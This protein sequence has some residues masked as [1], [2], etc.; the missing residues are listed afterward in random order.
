LDNGVRILFEKIPICTFGQR[1]NLGGTG[2]RNE[3]AYE[4]G[5]A[6]FIEHMVFKAPARAHPPKVAE[7]MDAIGGQANAFTSKGTDMLLRKGPGYAS[8]HFVGCAQ[9]YVF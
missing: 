7:L 3:K 9:R 5:A 2:S 4:C 1:R 8:G 6:H